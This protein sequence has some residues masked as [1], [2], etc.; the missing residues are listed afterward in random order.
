MREDGCPSPLTPCRTITRPG[1]HPGGTVGSAD[2]HRVHPLFRLLLT[3]HRHVRRR[4]PES[5]GVERQAFGVGAGQIRNR[6][7]G[8]RLHPRRPVGA[9]PRLHVPRAGQEAGCRAFRPDQREG[10]LLSRRPQPRHGVHLEQAQGPEGDRRPRRPADGHVQVR[11]LQEGRGRQRALPGRRGL[12][13]EDDR[14][15][16][17]GRRRLRASAGPRAAADRARWRR[18][19]RCRPCRRQ[20][21]LRLL[22]PGGDARVARDRHG[23]GL[24]ARLSQGTRLAD[25][26]PGGR[27]GEGGGR[28]FQGYRS[29][30]ADPDHRHLSEARQL[31][32]A[33]GDHQAGLRGRARHFP[34]RRA[35][36]QAARL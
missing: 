23:Q 12:D 6:R 20:R 19:H 18:P 32:A 2:Q 7:P 29:G 24:H 13:R 11:L 4:L 27:G 28:V 33:R 22:E 35:H 3:S 17:Q 21:H 1:V 26:N 8:R 30:R 16:P 31:D 10:R 9:L 15:L 36:H 34:A 25:R 14:R 5:R